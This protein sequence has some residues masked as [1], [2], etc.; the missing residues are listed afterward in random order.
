VQKLQPIPVP[1]AISP[2]ISNLVITIEEDGD[3]V[4]S[5]NVYSISTDDESNIIFEDKRVLIT[6][7]SGQW[8]RTYPLIDQEDLK[9]HGFVNAVEFDSNNPELYLENFKLNWRKSM[10]CPDSGVYEVDNSDWLKQT[11]GVEWKLK[12][13]VCEGHDFWFEL[14][15]KGFTWQFIDN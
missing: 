12:H 8:L 5:G 2:S 9:N 4:V 10:I 3:V 15:A 11:N 1:W 6:F 7:K 14:L 13:F